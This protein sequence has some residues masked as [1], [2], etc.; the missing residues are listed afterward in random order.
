MN[1][2]LGSMLSLFGLWVWM[3]IHPTHHPTVTLCMNSSISSPTHLPIQP[4]THPSIYPSIH[5]GVPTV[6]QPSC[7]LTIP[8]RDDIAPVQAVF[9]SQC[10]W[11][12][13]SFDSTEWIQVWSSSLLSDPSSY[14]VSCA[15]L[16]ILICPHMTEISNQFLFFFYDSDYRYENA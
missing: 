4:P 10:L 12:D 14:S 16:E 9:S 8:F 15:L 6:C 5:P 7:S 13:L 1:C 3:P 11:L 2:L